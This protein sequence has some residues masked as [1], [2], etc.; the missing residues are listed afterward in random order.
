MI[1]VTV[2]TH[3]KAFDR[4]IRA[5]DEACGLLKESMVIQYGVS[6]YSLKYAQGFDFSSKDK[7]Q[8]LSASARL[9][10]T[11]A[12][13]GSLITSLQCSAALLVVP[14]LRRYNE[15]IDDHQLELAKGLAEQGRAVLVG[16][17]ENLF[18]EIQK[19]SSQNS[20]YADFEPLADYIA[21]RMKLLGDR[22]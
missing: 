16:N 7:I 6:S 1:F 17:I 11:Q 14:R 10:I 15:S 13:A 19:I 4:L 21:T 9:I 12:G 20:K 5:A 2:G 3:S 18:F 22:F 8:E